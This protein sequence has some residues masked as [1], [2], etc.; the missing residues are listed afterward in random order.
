[1]REL[2]IVRDRTAE[3]R[4]TTPGRLIP[5]S[6]LIAAANAMPTDRTSLLDTPGFHGRGARRY[7]D[8]WL[9]AIDRARKLRDSELP[10]LT[11]RTDAPPQQR[12]W[13]ERDPVAAARL[14]KAREANNAFAEEHEVPVENLLTPDYLRRVLWRPPDADAAE[15]EEAVARELGDLGARPWQITITAPILADAIVDPGEI[16]QPPPGRSR[17]RERNGGEAAKANGTHGNSTPGNSTKRDKTAG[18]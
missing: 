18:D 11:I 4:D 10:P 17:N 13:V 9:A 12:V 8:Q 16:P 14:T 15:M 7:A 1:V 6:A 2:W 3:E 5:D